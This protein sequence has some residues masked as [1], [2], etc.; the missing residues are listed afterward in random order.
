[1]ALDGVVG[2]ESEL[3]RIG[4]FLGDGGERLA[5]WLEGVAGI[6]KTTLWRAGVELAREQGHRVLT[7]RP[8]AAETAFSYAALGDLLANA[9]EEVLPELPAPQ[10]RALEVAVALASSEGP[11]VSERVIGLA[12]LSTLQLLAAQEPVLVAIDDVQWLDPAS[13]AVLQFAARR[14]TD[15]RVKLLVAARLEAPSRALPLERDLSERSARIAVG[16]LSMGALHRLVLSRV[17]EP[18]SRPTLRRV[19]D[20]S[21]GN[22]FYALEIARF[23]VDGGMPLRPAEPLPIPRKLDELVRARLE[24]LP[25]TVRHVLEAAALVAEPTPA[26]LVAVGSEPEQVGNRLDRAVA[27]GVIEL[28]EDRVRFTHPLLAAAIVSGIGSRRRRQLHARLAQIAVDPEERARHLA[29]GTEGADTTVAES[30]EEAAQH[31]ALRGAPVVAAE[32]A[33]LAA[34][35]TPSDEQEQRW[36]RLIEAGLRYAVAGDLHRA[37][38]LLGPLTEEIP[39]GPLR[40][41]VLLNLADFHWDEPDVAVELAET[42]LTEVGGDHRCRARLHML[43]SSRALEAQTGSALPRIRAALEAA[44]RSGDEELTL[45]ALVNS[46]H[47]EVCAGEL[48]PGLLERGLAL[49]SAQGGGSDRIPHFESPSIPLG[50]ALLGLGRFEEARPLLERA[51]ADSFDQGVPFAAAV[52]ALFLAELECRVGAWHE[53]ELHAAECWELYEPLGTNKAQPCYA[54]ALV[55]AHVGKVERARAAGERGVA[56][57]RRAGLEFW[58]FA[59]RRVLGLLELSLGNPAAA[60][61]YLQL[62]ARGSVAGL[63]RM[64]CNCD[65]LETAIEALVSVGDL[66]AAA[67]LLEELAVWSKPMDG[68]WSRAVRARCCGLL[69]SAQGEHDGAFTAFEEALRQHERLHMPFDRARTLLGLGVLQ[70][71]VKRRRAARQSLEAALA[72]F[73]ELGARLWVERTRA[74]LKRIGGRAP[75]GDV[76]TATERRVAE[77]VAEGHS[78]KAVAARLF[79]TVKAVEANLTRVYAKLGIHSRTELTRLLAHDR[80]G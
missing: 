17:G 44:E 63:W 79:V 11:A 12:L 25:G 8:T 54:R 55:D 74:E 64:P 30:L 52:A 75:G 20:A 42:A 77:L 49:V 32:L 10:R 3:E 39:P 27:A 51:R 5:L 71:K 16:P 57:A 65:Y 31:A 1:L 28:D 9:A 14:L 43:L 21:A 38:A 67:E 41:D 19:H 61:E 36:R 60:V 80:P 45:L 4:G 33:E 22:P 40:A 46:V 66:D 72:V 47:V 69:S 59:N 24:R 37:Q 70:R 26:A 2:R 6:G 15:E 35:R 62:P 73:E 23:L 13:A 56:D 7:C 58:S 48:T 68:P 34:Q 29:L 18:L 53:A 78:N 76:L 50:L